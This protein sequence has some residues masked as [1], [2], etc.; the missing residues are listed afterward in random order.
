MNDPYTQTDTPSLTHSPCFDINGD[1]VPHGHHY[2]P[3]GSPCSKCLCHNGQS[4]P[5]D[6]P[7]ICIM[8][9]CEKPKCQKYKRVPG[10]CCDYKCEDD[11]EITD[12]A[13]LAIV[14]SL[15]IVLVCTLIAI[16]LVLRKIRR[17]QLPFTFT[18]RFTKRFG[19]RLSSISLTSQTQTPMET[20]IDEMI[21]KHSIP[22]NLR[23]PTSSKNNGPPSCSSYCPKLDNTKVVNIDSS[24]KGTLNNLHS[25]SSESLSSLCGKSN[26]DLDSHSIDEKRSDN[27]VK[28]RHYEPPS[29]RSPLLSTAFI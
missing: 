23:Q 17:K 14:V 18:K 6:Q 25:Y 13:T 16:T 12:K 22:N 4:G 28:L 7:G 15:S 20:N 8:V 29:V 19:N 26:V 21:Q 11:I 1:M 9:S 3:P 2:T 24:E 10:K 5:L 27:S